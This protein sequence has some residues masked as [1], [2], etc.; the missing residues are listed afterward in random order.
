MTC[1]EE[2]WVRG[3]RGHPGVRQSADW[4]AMTAWF[5][6]L[7]KNYSCLFKPIIIIGICRAVW[8]CRKPKPSLC[9]GRWHGEA[10]T[11]GL[12]GISDILHS[13][14]E[15]SNPSV[16]FADT[17]G[18]LGAPAPV[19]HPGNAQFELLPIGCARPISAKVSKAFYQVP[20]KDTSVPNASPFP[21]SSK[22]KNPLYNYI[23]DFMKKTLTKG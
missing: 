21:G 5:C 22:D 15:K 14:S 12:H 20:V 8:V 7:S 17:Q 4:L 13:A 2:G 6:K 9:K 1:K 3:K 19:Q 18:S 23:V 11:E 10:V 16:S